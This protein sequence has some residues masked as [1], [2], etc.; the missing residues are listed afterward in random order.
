MIKLGFGGLIILL[1]LFVLFSCMSIGN[2][3]L[4]ADIDDSEADRPILSLETGSHLD[5]V[6][7]LCFTPDNKIFITASA[8]KTIRLWDMETGNQ[9]K[10]IRGFNGS[11]RDGAIMATDLSPDGSLLAVSVVRSEGSVIRLISIPGGEV[12]A[13]LYGHQDQY[14]ETVCFSPDGKYLASGGIDGGA[15]LWNV[16]E[17]KLESRINYEG[18]TSIFEMDFSP[19]G[20]LLAIATAREAVFLWSVAQKRVVKIIEGHNRPITSVS[21]TADGNAILTTGFDG[22]ARLWN[23]SSGELIRVVE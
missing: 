3:G 1:S 6:N 2:S 16:E 12:V 22:S 20:S 10:V 11:G 4:N 13:N 21:F 17:Q 8:D 14:V 9:L 18:L 19:D 5:R 15:I 23:T 7:G